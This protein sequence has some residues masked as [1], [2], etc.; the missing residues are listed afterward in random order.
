MPALVVATAG[1]PA[2]SRMRAVAASQALGNRRTSGPR[3]NWRSRS[4]LCARSV[5]LGVGTRVI[6]AP[7]NGLRRIR[8]DMGENG[9]ETRMRAAARQ[10]S[11]LSIGRGIGEF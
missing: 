8:W 2:A 9:F 1:Y 5:A 3:C 7:Q 6:I 11:L 10:Q 4:A